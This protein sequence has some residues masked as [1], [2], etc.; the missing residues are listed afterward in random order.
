MSVTPTRVGRFRVWVN[1]V[2]TSSARVFHD[3]ESADSA[4]DF[5]KQFN[6]EFDYIVRVCAAN[7]DLIPISEGTW[8]PNGA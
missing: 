7:G 5:I 8:K 1:I 3:E 2:D 4:L 6:V